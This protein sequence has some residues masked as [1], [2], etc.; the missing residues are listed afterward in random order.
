M[1]KEDDLQVWLQY[2]EELRMVGY[3][4]FEHADVKETEKGAADPQVIAMAMLC[5]T[6]S[7]HKAIITLLK[8]ESILEARI[9]TRNC[10]E[11]AFH[12]A[13]LVD[14]GYEFVKEMRAS[15]VASRKAIGQLVMKYKDTM[16]PEVFDKLRHDLRE[17]NK[18]F[19]NVKTLEPKGI[20]QRSVFAEAYLYYRHLSFDAHPSVTTL[21]QYIMRAG[22]DGGTERGIDVSPIP[23]PNA[24]RDTLDLA[25]HA[26]LAVVVGT[27]Q[28]VGTGK[29]NPK[30]GEMTN[31]YSALAG[32]TQGS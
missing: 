11:N 9:L 28:L 13:L 16:A 21:D 26:V 10:F 23:K 3:A 22:I 2:A 19:A 1:P 30:L 18:R 12:M 17:M 31:R 32:I 5:R 7:H 29:V 8:Q 15:D 27:N 4:V 20:A 25:C 6:L 14:E 24:A